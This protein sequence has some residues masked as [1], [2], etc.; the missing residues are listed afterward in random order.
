MTPLSVHPGRSHQVGTPEGG[1]FPLFWHFCQKKVVSSTP[2]RETLPGVGGRADPRVLRQ[3]FDPIPQLFSSQLLKVGW[4]VMMFRLWRF[5]NWSK[6][7]K[8]GPKGPNYQ[9]QI[10]GR[11]S[12]DDTSLGIFVVRFIC[13]LVRPPPSPTISTVEDQLQK[14][15]QLL[16]SSWKEAAGQPAAS[17]QPVQRFHPLSWALPSWRSL[18]DGLFIVLPTPPPR[19]WI[20]DE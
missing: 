8:N 16:T 14:L 7:H 5:T 3:I 12:F 13:Y 20:S 11:F 19:G 9:R 6:T 1:W 2:P 10:V 15:V 18:I 17:F 4:M